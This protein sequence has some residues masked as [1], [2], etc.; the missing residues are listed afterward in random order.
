MSSSGATA[1]L[2]PGQGAQSVGMVGEWCSNNS[3]ALGLFQKAS[4]ILGY[5]LFEIC[6]AGP[7]EKLNTTAVS[8]PGILVASLAALEFLRDRDPAPLESATITAGLSLG[9]YTAL[10]FAGVLSFEDAV[11]LVD[12]RGRAMQACAEQ[13]PGGMV[14]I[15]GLER[16]KVEDICAKA[17]QQDELRVANVL[18]PGNIVVS[19]SDEACRRVVSEA[20]TAG[21]MKTV[22]LDV[23]G[24]FHTVLMKPAVEKLRTA[25]SAV[26]MQSPR[27]PVIS[28]VDARPHTNPEEIRVLLAEQ[29]CGVVEWNASMDYMLSTQVQ[30]VWEVGPG[31]VLRGLLKRINRRKTCHGVFD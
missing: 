28:N 9:E 25:L 24:A 13:S 30:S 26:S 16:E 8:Q 6:C 20:A 18:C 3:A 15:L 10:V 29:V 27:I 11:R 17:R 1:I 21:A 4:E 2:F 19:G 12:V 31:R 7:S 5:D 14:A 23:A 22:R